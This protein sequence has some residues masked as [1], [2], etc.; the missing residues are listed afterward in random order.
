MSARRRQEDVPT[1]PRDSG[2][3][4]AA[5][6]AGLVVAGVAAYANS[7]S[8]P[9]IFD[10]LMSIP[11][12]PTLHG[13]LSSFLPPGGGVTVT[14]RPFLN[15]S[16]AVNQVLSGDSVWSYHALNLL[17]HLLAGLTL[18]GIVR[19]TLL[20]VADRNEV[21]PLPPGRPTA[22]TGGARATTAAFLVAL[23]W[24]IHPLQTESVT[25]IVQ[26]AESLMGLFYLFALYGFIRGA[27]LNA[28]EPASRT[29]TDPRIRARSWRWFWLSF[30]SCLLGVMTK[31]VTVSIPVIVLLYDRAFLAGSFAAAFRR[32][33]R[34]HLALASTWIVLLALVLHA[35]DRGGTA[36]F[37]VVSFW[38][39]AATQFQ[40]LSHYLWLAVWPH[41]L[42]V[43]YGVQWA[44]S[45]VDIA[46]YVPGILL[47]IAATLIA[48]V[49]RPRL[50]FLG[51]WFF[52]ILAPTSLVPGNRQTLAEHRMYLALAP[53]VVV[54]VL[55]V[56]R[57]L[58]RRGATVIVGGALAL[59]ALTAQRNTIY[60]TDVGIWRD[61]VLSRPGNAFA[62]N[63]YGNILAQSGRPADA[64]VQFDEALRLKPDY[65]EP[66]YNAGNALRKL[67]RLPE[68]I[69]RY[70]QALRINPAMPDAEV[71]LGRALEE[72]GRDG[73]AMAHYEQAL[74]I[75]SRYTEALN[76]IGL[77][78]QRAGHV[79]EAIARY[80]QALQ[81]DPNLATVHDNLG[82]ALRAAGRAPEA[83]AEYREALRLNPNLAAAHNNLGNAYREADRQ[84]EAIAEYEAALKL[85]PDAAEV[86]NNLGISLL[87]AGR[88]A[89]AIAQFEAALRLD[90]NLGRTHLNLALALAS[91]GR[92]SEAETHFQRAKQLGAVPAGAG[93]P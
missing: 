73:E 39:Y 47:L 6:I 68:A 69:A 81:I 46:P 50:G 28:T 57:G 38:A 54:A 82:N 11:Q 42:I 67:G 61:T 12:N 85:A 71:G 66:A 25:Y 84:P 8:G 70:E 44:R 22:T 55:A 78:L 40:A 23:V 62:H 43:D 33:G 1:P 15:F 7:F 48:L 26:R 60:H 58:G 92:E 13:L 18:F 77:A 88:T 75:N 79:P 19:R 20:L 93:G 51:F 35:S 65:A 63:N 30:I 59:G 17:I 34:V 16:F 86:H 56:L 5:A 91:V 49:R 87:I 53:V 90:P 10:D 76:E 4:V 52:A 80:R 27:E 3:G 64:V 24:T 32:R 72:A 29:A 31:E 9:F 74:R 2:R 89:E 37:G 83:I 41:P 21:R 14:G 36:G 45:A